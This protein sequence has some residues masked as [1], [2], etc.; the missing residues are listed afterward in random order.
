MVVVLRT[1]L[2][3]TRDVPPPFPSISSFLTSIVCLFES[4]Y[5]YIT[6]EVTV[7]RTGQE[8]GRCEVGEEWIYGS[9]GV[10]ASGS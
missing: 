2:S 9:G 8:E 3:H 7:L 5:V 4:L 6:F 10:G 1:V